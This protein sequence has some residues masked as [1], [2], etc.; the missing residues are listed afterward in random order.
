MGA[1]VRAAAAK[2]DEVEQSEEEAVN[3]GHN[4]AVRV[5][6]RQELCNE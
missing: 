2:E 3:G 1:T 6:G 5:L 4:D